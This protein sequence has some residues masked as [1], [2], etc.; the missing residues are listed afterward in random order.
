M[1]MSKGTLWLLQIDGKTVRASVLQ[2]GHCIHRV[3]AKRIKGI[4]NWL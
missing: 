4:Q 2:V 3:G 1:L